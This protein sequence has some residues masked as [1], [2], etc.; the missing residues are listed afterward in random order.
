MSIPD[1]GKSKIE[2]ICR[3]NDKPNLLL[4]GNSSS[5]SFENAWKKGRSLDFFK[6]ENH[7]SYA[8]RT[9]A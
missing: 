3:E 8:K 6:M 2:S 5:T 1:G 9:Q 4:F 7:E